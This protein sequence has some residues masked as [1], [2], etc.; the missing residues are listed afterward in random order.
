MSNSPFKPE[1]SG[2]LLVFMQPGPQVS[3]EEFHEWYDTEHVPLRIHRFPTF[4]SAVR[5]SVSSSSFHPPGDGIE[6]SWGAFYTVSSNS[7]FADPSYTSLRSERSSREAELFTRLAI[8]DR[9]IYKLEYDS[10]SDP[11]I[12]SPKKIGLGVQ[13]GSD[14]PIYLV[15]NSVTMKESAQEEY[16]RWF[17]E[18]HA[19]MLSKIPGWRRSRRFR[20][21]DNG[22]NGRESKEGD[23]ERVPKCLGLHGEY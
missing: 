3:L 2:L 20:L 17:D 8:V 13:K 6:S 5:Y 4:R 1:D 9:R 11:T 12:D 15:T 21:V 10:D 23:A 16:N 19:P 22:V 14:A 18:E 7:T